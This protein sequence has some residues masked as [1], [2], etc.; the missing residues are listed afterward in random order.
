MSGGDSNRSGETWSE[1]S[2]TVRP[3]RKRSDLWREDP[4]AR[5]KKLRELRQ[6][7]AH[8]KGEESLSDSPYLPGPGVPF[9]PANASLERRLRRGQVGIDASLDLHGYRLAEAQRQLHRFVADKYRTGAA[10]LL[11][12][13]G[14]GS[15]RDNEQSIRKALPG[16]VGRADLASM[17]RSLHPAHEKHGGSGAF[18]LL[19]EKKSKRI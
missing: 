4:Q 9:R 11:V 18:Y 5:K 16:W 19:L 6:R 2:R 10:C 14:K 1:I 8:R 7:A 17:V 15:L 13:T 3:L 12:I